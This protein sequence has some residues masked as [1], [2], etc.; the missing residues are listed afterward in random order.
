MPP[1]A[2]RKT[3]GR[4][5]FRRGPSEAI[6]RSAFSRLPWFRQISQA[7]G[8]PLLAHLDQIFGVETK[9]AACLEHGFQRRHIDRMLP[10]VVGGAA[11]IP[12]AIAFRHHKGRKALGPAL[13]LPA[14]HIPVAVSQHG[15][16]RVALETLGDQ[17]RQIR[18]R[19]TQDGAEETHGGESGQHFLFQIKRQLLALLLILAF[20]PS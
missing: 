18:R 13:I 9:P 1:R 2:P 19:V 6:R 14:H 7:G 5:A 4:S 10:L 16:Q 12:P 3:V 17:K 15:R 20:G 11:P 8:A